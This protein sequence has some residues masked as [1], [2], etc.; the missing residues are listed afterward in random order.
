MNRSCSFAVLL[1]LESFNHID[2]LFFMKKDQ[3]NNPQTRREERDQKKLQSGSGN[4]N[5][6]KHLKK[7]FKGFKKDTFINNKNIKI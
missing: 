1:D 5:S 6:L 7:V 4:L 2:A 3:K